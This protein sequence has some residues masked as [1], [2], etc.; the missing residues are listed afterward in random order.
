MLGRHAV[1][2]VTLAARF[3]YVERIYGGARVGFGKDLVRVAVAA[4]A[5]MLLA[6]GVHAAGESGGLVVVAGLALDGRDLVGMRVALDIGVAIRALQAAMNALAEFLA[7]NGD[8]VA[9]SVGHAGIAVAGQ[10]VSLRT[11]SAGREC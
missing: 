5:R 10:T 9:G 6:V 1:V 2:A 7:V 8:A 4:R 11:K 3:G